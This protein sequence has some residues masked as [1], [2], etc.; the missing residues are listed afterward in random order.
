[1]PTCV[2]TTVLD[3]FVR[4]T[5]NIPGRWSSPNRT[6]DIC[7]CKQ[8]VISFNSLARALCLLDQYTHMILFFNPKTRQVGLKPTNDSTE[9]GT[10]RLRKAGTRGLCI[11]GRSFASSNRIDYTKRAHYTISF[12]PELGM[13][14]TMKGVAT[15]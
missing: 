2:P 6:P 4:F 1:M 8:G 11:S 14:V 12:V 3:S 7:I 10:I 5:K 13:F 15:K 9:P